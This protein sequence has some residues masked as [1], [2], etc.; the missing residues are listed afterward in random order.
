MPQPFP[1]LPSF[2]RRPW[3]KSGHR[4]RW[5]GLFATTRKTT[6]GSS[7]T[8]GAMDIYPWRMA[9]GEPRLYGASLKACVPRVSVDTV[10]RA[11]P[12][13]P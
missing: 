7:V 1:P 9:N 11:A 8:R 12:G 4:Q 6:I 3:S 13:Y 5:G 10:G 2:P